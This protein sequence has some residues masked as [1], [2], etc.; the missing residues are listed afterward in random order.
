MSTAISYN[1]NAEGVLVAGTEQ[2]VAGEI[3]LRQ[4]FGGKRRT[5]RQTVKLNAVIQGKH[6]TFSATVIDIS[7]NGVLMHIDDIDGGS[8]R[9]VSSNKLI[10]YSTVV[11]YHFAWMH[12]RFKSDI[13]DSAFFGDVSAGD[14]VPYIPD[15]QLFVSLGFESEP[16][17]AYLS[18]NYV[19]SVCTIAS[20]GEF[21]ATGSSTIVD[22]GVHYT[23]TDSV[24]LYAA[25]ENL[26]RELAI[27]ARQPYGARPGKDRSWIL[28]IKL[29]F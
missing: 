23:L 5:V 1:K 25:V 24:E 21:E 28:G 2:P 27:A 26:S 13:G 8:C 18:G 6:D 10:A 16:W 11:L 17:S 3:E 19:D 22:L 15:H 9:P 12:A 7:R 4:F 14:P 29:D 20:C